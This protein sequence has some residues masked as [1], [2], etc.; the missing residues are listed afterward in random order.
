M[1]QA[2]ERMPEQS[3][4]IETGRPGKKN[5]G[6]ILAAILAA[7]LFAALAAG[8]FFC[9]QQDILPLP[10]APESGGQAAA[11]GET[12]AQLE[13]PEQAADSG[14]AEDI[15][16]PDAQAE[17]ADQPETTG[18]GDASRP[19]IRAESADQPETAGA[20]GYTA[21]VN[22]SASSELQEKKRGVYSAVHVYDNS[23]NTPWCENAGGVGIGEW[24]QVELDGEQQVTAL[25]F[26]NGFMESYKLLDANSQ[27]HNATLEFSD[28]SRQSVVVGK[29]TTLDHP[30][31]VRLPAPV[32]TSSI[33]ITIDSAYDGDQFEDTCLS[34][35]RVLALGGTAQLPDLRH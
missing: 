21:I 33:K 15:L 34:E 6:R 11:D 16:Q 27:I 28:G 19:D 14:T 9:F 35:L 7:I 18:A 22:A 26:Y 23:L 25:E 3:D 8:G 1:E 29:N 5:K 4:Q 24:I 12:T 10:F 2:P 32:L 31:T 20:E 13:Q 30:V 17:S